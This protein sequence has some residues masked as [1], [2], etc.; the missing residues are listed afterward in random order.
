VTYCPAVEQ[1]S[2]NVEPTQV[3]NEGDCVPH[4]PFVDIGV[5]VTIQ[6]NDGIS[7]ISNQERDV[8]SYEHKNMK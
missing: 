1:Q 4:T 2:P 8:N 6:N 5:V 3:T 7:S